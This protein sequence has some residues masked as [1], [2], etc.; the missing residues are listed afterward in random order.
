M[1]KLEGGLLYLTRVAPSLALVESSLLSWQAFCIARYHFG[2][3]LARVPEAWPHQF[4]V[5][6]AFPA[7]R[8]SER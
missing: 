8:S 1:C 7:L 5:C 3:P 2:T 4:P 6:K